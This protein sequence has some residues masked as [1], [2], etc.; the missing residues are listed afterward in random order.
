MRH[1][2]CVP[3]RELIRTVG[4]ARRQPLPP[5][6]LNF[7]PVLDWVDRVPDQAHWRGSTHLFSLPVAVRSLLVCNLFTMDV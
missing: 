5:R 3:F 4:Q 2:P 7:R 6:L 1:T